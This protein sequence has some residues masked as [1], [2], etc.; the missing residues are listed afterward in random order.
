M[1]TQ[2]LND[3]RTGGENGAGT[4]QRGALLPRGSESVEVYGDERK[5]VLGVRDT[6]TRKK[7][8]G[9]G[10]VRRTVNEQ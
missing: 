6:L 7:G 2:L 8:E 1:E 5:E 4:P 3:R 10:P 9:Q